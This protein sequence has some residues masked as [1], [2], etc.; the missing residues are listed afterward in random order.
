ML[1]TFFAFVALSGA[2]A[3]SIHAGDKPGFKDTPML[4]DQPWRV[5]DADRPSPR[6]VTP[7]AAFSHN[8]PAPSDAVVL[9][10]GRDLS[11][12]TGSNGE[13]RWKVEDGY[14]QVTDKAGNI[15]TKDEFEDFQ[16]HIEFATPAKVEGNGQE[17]GNSGVFIHDR[18]EVQVLDSF[19]NPTY[20]DGQAG[21]MYGQFPPLVNPI[22][23]PGE[24]Q[25]YDII[26]EAPR[27][28]AAGK[29]IKKAN[30]TVILNGVVVHHKKEYIGKVAHKEVGTY[31]DVT[32][33]RG[34]IT[35]QDHGD[36]V[37]FRNIWVRSL[38]NYDQ[39]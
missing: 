22:K 19:K 33:S 36:P 39:P 20:P 8:A 7:G 16:L 28:D 4:P 32:S 30:V 9:F 23:P 6:V 2:A 21:A 17:R 15:R 1:K 18:Y 24:W 25:S 26:F 12:W 3:A 14:M 5:H 35:L 10:D 13:A 34:A 29:V 31:Q 27:W 37:R 38:G 11:K